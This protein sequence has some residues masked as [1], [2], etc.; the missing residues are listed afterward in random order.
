MTVG[1][2]KDNKGKVD[3]DKL[4]SKLRTLIRR[5]DKINPQLISTVQEAADYLQEVSG[6]HYGYT[7][8]TSNTR[9]HRANP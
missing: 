1:Q 2:L 4:L 8:G 3:D 5:V 9:P 7:T 6:D